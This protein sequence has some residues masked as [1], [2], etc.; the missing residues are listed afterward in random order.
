MEFVGKTVEETIKTGLS[1]MGL[2]EEQAEITVK[3][4]PTKG[5][6][7][8]LKGKAVVEITAKA[9]GAQKA[10]EF[11]QKV[12]E[13][14]VTEVTDRT[15]TNGD[16]EIFPKGKKGLAL[17]L[18]YFG[19]FKDENTIN[20][21]FY[22]LK[23]SCFVEGENMEPIKNPLERIEATK[24]A[25]SATLLFLETLKDYPLC[26]S[27]AALNWTEGERNSLTMAVAGVL[28]KVAK[29]P[30]DEAINVIGDT[31]AMSRPHEIEYSI[32]FCSDTIE[33]VK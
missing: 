19:L 1:E 33:A 11:I 3:E 12:L 25:N 8:K 15:I 27:K 23:K 10:T 21:D 22:E 24:K 9:T 6:F 28:K 14:L 2:S 17:N 20:E 18:P 30:I 13:N 29:T 5:L 7:G 16:I 31:V 32:T 26:V 4:Q